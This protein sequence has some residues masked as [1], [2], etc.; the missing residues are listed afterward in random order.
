MEDST[1]GKLGL[2]KHHLALVHDLE[3]NNL[4]KV[5]LDRKL[6]KLKDFK[7]IDD[8]PMPAGFKGTLRPYQKSGFNWLQ[9]LRKYNFGGCLA[10]G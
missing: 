6:E 9:F 10:D 3:N 5:M 1:K 2:K 8:Y 4:A 7:E